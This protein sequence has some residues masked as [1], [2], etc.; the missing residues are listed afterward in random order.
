MRIKGLKIIYNNE[1]LVSEIGYYI[2]EYI[3]NLDKVLIDLQRVGV[4]IFEAKS[5][6]CQVSIKI[7]GYICNINSRYLNTSKF[8]KILD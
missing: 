6:F 7:V 4:T 8:L 1:E 2:V 5:Q 3:L